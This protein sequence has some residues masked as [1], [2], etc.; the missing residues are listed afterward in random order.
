MREL[1]TELNDRV[2]RF[3]GVSIVDPENLEGLLLRGA[4]PNK[5]RTTTTTTTVEQYNALVPDHEKIREFELEPILFTY[6]WLLPPKYLSLDIEEHMSVVFGERLPSL[7]YDSAQTEIAITRVTLELQKF[8]E[9]GLYDLLRVIVF[10]LDR[11]RETGQIWGVGRGSSCA[12]LILF[13]LGLHVVDPI[14]FD[15]PLEEFFHD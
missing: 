1:L 14:K 9:R 5:L 8:R 15:V 10:V 6:G 2:L 3:D 13:L 12:S 7:K 11:F 4:M